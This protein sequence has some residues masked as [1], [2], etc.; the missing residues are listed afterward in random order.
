MTHGATELTNAL[1]AELTRAMRARDSAATGALRA[2]LADLAN[3][4]S[5]AIDHGAPAPAGD[6]H[7]AGSAPGLGAA[8]APRHLLG[9]AEARDI[10]AQEVS[11]RRASAVEFRAQGRTGEAADLARGADVLDA[12]LNSSH[13]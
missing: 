12:V 8:E 5:V 10:V 13:P 3:A 4:E 11:A 7:V 9:E 2:A 6:H 1:R